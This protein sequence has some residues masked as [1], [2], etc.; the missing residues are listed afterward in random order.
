MRKLGN[1]TDNINKDFTVSLAHE[2]CMGGQVV[3]ST[4][5]VVRRFHVAH[6]MTLLQRQG[7]RFSEADAELDREV[8]MHLGSTW[9]PQE[10]QG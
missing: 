9:L 10:M 3:A 6:W 4:V 2:R 1:Y 7:G 5:L 8:Q